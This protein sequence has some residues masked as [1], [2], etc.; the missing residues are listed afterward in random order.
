M[1]PLKFREFR[2]GG[3]E[4]CGFLCLSHGVCR[5]REGGANL[6]EG[7]LFGNLALHLELFL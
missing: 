5:F 3:I 1:G 7:R 2:Q 4:I 6:F